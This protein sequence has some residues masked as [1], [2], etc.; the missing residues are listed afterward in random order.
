V[1]L[2]C[3]AFVFCC[4]EL[5]AQDDPAPVSR[6]QEIENAQSVKAQG[7]SPDKPSPE[8]QRFVHIEKELRHVLAGQRL[9][10]KFGGL[11]MPAGFAFGP[12][13]QWQNRDDRVRA[14]VWAIGSIRKFYSV[15]TGLELPRLASE[16]LTFR[17]EAAHTDSPQLAF[18]GEGPH[19]LKSQRTDYRR[20]DTR[21]DAGLD[22]PASRHLDA[23]CKAEQLFLNVGRGTNDSVTSTNLKFTAAQAPGL[24]V[25][26]DF[27]IAG[28]GLRL[29]FRDIPDNP[30]K[31]TSV[32]LRGNRYLAEDFGRYSF[33]RAYGSIE[34]Y[35]PFFNRKR[36]IA[37]HT[38]ADMTFHNRDQVVP[39]YMQ[40]TLGGFNDL[41]G[42][43]PLRFYDENSF[44]MNA[45]YRWEICTGL[46]L[47]L[48]GDAGEVFHRPGEFKVANLQKA[49]GFGFRFNN[50]RN[51]V[52]RIDTGFSREGFQ[53][54]A[55]FEKLF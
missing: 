50:Q 7:L 17:V 47:A 29:E 42:F 8:E 37:L 16:R 26:S 34:E 20:E 39:F 32:V 36:V 25:Q 38:A 22:W 12:T 2:S 35:I 18:Y 19:S 10:L 44:V 5:R 52:M 3:L 48:F 51:M 55:A 21:F 54:W 46:D 4:A 27:L 11:S 40:P 14:N 1:A 23:N 49:A 43:R 15:G 24:D 6:A 53:V 9:H 13:L 30:H 45:E 28:C 41:R 33:N 31:G